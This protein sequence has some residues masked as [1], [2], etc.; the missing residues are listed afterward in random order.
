MEP[1]STDIKSKLQPQKIL[2]IDD[3]EDIRNIITLSL[4]MA[5][6]EIIIAR[7]GLDGL[8]A[9]KMHKPD[10]I[11]CDVNM[12]KM[13]GN[14][15]L[16]II[17]ED[18]EFAGTP[19]IFL[20]GNTSI[21]DMRK[22]M[23]LGADD[24]L[25][26]PF[27]TQEL[28]TAVKTRLE[29][30]KSLQKYYEFQFD[31]IKT[32]IVRFLP[33]EFR[34][35]LSVVIGFSDI[36]KTEGSLPAEE[37]RQIGMMIGNSARRLHRLLE[38][39]ILFGQLQLL[40]HDEEKIKKL[41]TESATSLMDIIQSAAEKQMADHERPGAV[42]LSL[43]NHL[44]QIS[45]DYL[46][47]IMEELLDNALKFSDRRT[48]IAISTELMNSH[49]SI[50]IRDEGRG[51]SQEQINKVSAFQQF[52][53]GFYEQQGAG[54]GLAIAKILIELHDGSISIESEEQKGTTV[55]ISLPRVM[56]T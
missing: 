41:R 53:R 1:V 20:T 36:L 33:H 7:N 12:P 3:D 14:T 40:M 10:L 31:D 11:L 47:K 18:V 37:V 19:F 9:I 5:G 38:N 51:M 45:S 50:T 52:E 55:R 21:D 8:A 15:L 23:Q 22:G 28:I 16:D 32:N 48:A 30:K 26:K 2:V 24:Y 54:L 17:K 56:N 46:T 43:N 4:K 25:T 29:K 6:Y 42:R 34:T 27:T 49:V 39:M 35:P 44:V 13:D